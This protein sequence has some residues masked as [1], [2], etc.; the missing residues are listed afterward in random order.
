[1]KDKRENVLNAMT[2][3]NFIP[4]VF[5]VLLYLSGLGALCGCSD[6]F[7]PVE[8]TGTPTEY[9]F[10][11]WL[12]KSTYLYEDEISKLS[13]SGDSVSQL[14]NALDDRYTRYVGPSKSESAQN[15]L[16][17]SI[18]EGDVGMEY[19]SMPGVMHPIYVKR[20]YH[21]GPAGRA[22][23]KKFSVITH[24]NEI[25]LAGDNAF[26]TY[27][28][29]L[30]TSREVILQVQKDGFSNTYKLTK[31][32]IYAPTVFIDTLFN[33]IFITI[34]EFKS[35]TSDKDYGTYGELRDYLDSTAGTTVPRIIDIRNNPGGIVNQ[36]VNMADLFVS[37]GKH[38]TQHWKALAPDGSGTHRTKTYKAKAG[39]IGETGKFLLLMNRN[40][41]SCSEIFAAA[42]AEGAKIPTAGT[43]TF[44]KGIGQS[45]WKTID[46]GLAIITS[47]E[48]VP[49]SGVSYNKIGIKPKHDCGNEDDTQCAVRIL[50]QIY[51]NSL[52][53]ETAQEEISNKDLPILKIK[54]NRDMDFGGAIV[55]GDSL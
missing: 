46:K 22:G 20:V 1:M 26:N 12:L 36:C 23:I 45:S 6:F 8:A 2:G 5:C 49:P 38:T 34:T 30:D 55:P 40:S 19:M 35:N 24:I 44:G 16:S 33:E 21:N 17:T 53:K 25:E 15:S 31:E 28:S 41:A 39:D 18:V 54:Q 4:S 52:S 42:L 11:Y 14:Y 48:F 50:K 37:E 3:A 51:G 10:N 47:L 27:N 29:V 13:E 7:E 43:T 32:T 9:E